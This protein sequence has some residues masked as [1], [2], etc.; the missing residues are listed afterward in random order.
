[1][2]RHEIGQNLITVVSIIS[3]AMD[4][5]PAVARKREQESLKTKLTQAYKGLVRSG[6]H[7][8]KTGPRHAA[9]SPQHSP[10]PHV[11]NPEI[12][13]N[14]KNTSYLPT[15]FSNHES[16][17]HIAVV[18]NWEEDWDE[19]LSEEGHASPLVQK[20]LSK[21]SLDSFKQ[22]SENV[23]IPEE[24]DSGKLAT[25]QTARKKNVPDRKAKSDTRRGQRGDSSS[26][27]AVSFLR[28]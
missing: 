2:V 25:G 27:I 10:E 17:H 3:A 5:T 12:E 14:S 24:H 11:V 6:N 28:H 8:P 21:A 7:F 19:E 13:S 16:N 15:V 18:S 23:Q 9:H 20:G 22:E 26:D 1:M 4:K